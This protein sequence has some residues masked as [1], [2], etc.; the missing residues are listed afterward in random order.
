[1]YGLKKALRVSWGTYYAATCS[2]GFPVVQI[3]RW[4]EGDDNRGWHLTDLLTII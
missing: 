4:L 2:I 3:H 1:M